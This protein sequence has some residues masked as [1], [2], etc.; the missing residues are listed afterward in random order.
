MTPALLR[1][2]PEATTRPQPRLRT[3]ERAGPLRVERAAPTRRRVGVVAGALLFAVVLAG[4]VSVHASTTQGQFELERLQD[5]ARQREAAYQQLRL[6][7]ADLQA[8]D[9][10][11]EQARRLGMVEPAKVT[12]L[13]PT[14]TT[15]SS[16]DRSTPSAA[17]PPSEA[18]QSWGRVKPHLDPR[19]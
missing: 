10:I 6:E 15:S 2:L 9:R 1:P 3:V 13:T 16:E 17:D 4:N 7:V 12:Y 11:V 19:R 14:A 5:S 8:P 18:A